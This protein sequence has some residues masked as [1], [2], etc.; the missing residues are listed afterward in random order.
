MQSTD[1]P[2]FDSGMKVLF[3]AL[4][5]PATAERLE[6]FWVSCQRMSLLEFIRARDELLREFSDGVER[7]SFQPGMIWAALKT[8]KAAGPSTTRVPSMASGCT[9]IS[10]YCRSVNEQ[11]RQ[12]ATS[13]PGK[14]P[15]LLQALDYN[16]ET[17]RQMHVANPEHTRLK[18][19]I[20]QC[21]MV[22]GRERED[23]PLY[24]TAYDRYGELRIELRA[25]EERQAKEIAEKQ[26]PQQA[27][28]TGRPPV[29]HVAPMPDEREMQRRRLA[30]PAV[31]SSGAPSPAAGAAIASEVR[32]GQGVEALEAALTSGR[33]S[34]E[35]AFEH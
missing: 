10:E 28:A 12:A 9:S 19:Q 26:S 22:L 21:A 16:R 15:G 29:R 11:L 3:A 17:W 2:E 34:L 20:A 4:D 23:T 25:L 6:A 33:A 18:H 13:D 35:E 32:V 27:G 1:R 7:K 5:K 30:I 31:P 24:K 14:H 8:L